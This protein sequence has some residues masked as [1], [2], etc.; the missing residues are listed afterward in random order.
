MRRKPIVSAI[1]PRKKELIELK[2]E[3]PKPEYQEATEVTFTAPDGTV[4]VIPDLPDD[5]AGVTALLSA[6]TVYEDFGNHTE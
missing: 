2:H 4:I 6:Q 3:N 1:K 5:L